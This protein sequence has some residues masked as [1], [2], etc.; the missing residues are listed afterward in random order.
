MPGISGVE[1]AR[2]AHE[3]RPGLPVLLA[4]G[5]SE[6]VLKGAAAKFQVI[7]KPYG[8]G[9]LADAVAEALGRQEEK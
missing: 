3:S 7:A 1:L 9:A 5:Y 8:P 4:S 6:E 2:R